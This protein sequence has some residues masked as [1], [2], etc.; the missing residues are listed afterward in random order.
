M[1]DGNCKNCLAE[2]RAKNAANQILQG[3]FFHEEK[4]PCG[5]CMALRTMKGIREKFQLV[6]S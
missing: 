3:I 6:K 4:P 2:Y 5:K 1:E